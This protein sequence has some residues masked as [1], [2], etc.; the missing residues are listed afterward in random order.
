MSLGCK[1]QYSTKSTYA[2]VVLAREQARSRSRP[3]TDSFFLPY[4]E[5]YKLLKKYWILGGLQKILTIILDSATFGS[6]FVWA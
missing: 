6:W 3:L 1:V 5:K 4:L 2:L